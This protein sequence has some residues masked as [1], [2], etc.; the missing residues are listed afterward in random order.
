MNFNDASRLTQD[1]NV[2]IAS[3]LFEHFDNNY[4]QKKIHKTE[5]VNYDLTFLFYMELVDRVSR[6]IYKYVL[7]PIMPQ[8]ITINN[9]PLV[10]ITKT[11]GNVSVVS[12]NSYNPFD[13]SI[14]G[15]FGTYNTFLIVP[16]NG[17]IQDDDLKTG[18]NHIA[19][20]GV[21]GDWETRYSVK[22][23]RHID[24][25]NKFSG[26]KVEKYDKITGYG[27][28]KLMEEF[29][30]DYEKSDDYDLNIYN[31]S[32]G[33]KFVAVPVA[34][35]FNQN[36]KSN[37]LWNYSIS[38]KAIAEAN[39]RG[40]EKPL[41]LIEGDPD[42]LRKKHKKDTVMNLLVRP[43]YK[44]ATTAIAGGIAK[45]SQDLFKGKSA[46]SI[47]NNRGDYFKN[48][49]SNLGKSLTSPFN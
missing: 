1:F 27:F 11:Q 41:W 16:N 28:T 22:M 32:F 10:T 17:Y 49:A 34:Y 9:Q 2:P 18:K 6:D 44:Y 24:E 5:D 20:Y 36:V 12:N 45:D 7:F 8:E 25:P 23:D 33:Q 46:E 14:A 39:I 3:Q 4:V 21:P 48:S 43:A 40:Y 15:T 35:S 19:F 37:M 26:E 42:A 31:L 30:D 29:F 47:V 38:F 13:V